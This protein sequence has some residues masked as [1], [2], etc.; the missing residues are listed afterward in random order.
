LPKFGFTGQEAQFFS[1][2]QTGLCINF[3][4]IPRGQCIGVKLDI[5]LEIGSESVFDNIFEIRNEPIGIGIR[6]AHDEL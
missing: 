2:V 4:G 5:K 1:V 6:R 3:F